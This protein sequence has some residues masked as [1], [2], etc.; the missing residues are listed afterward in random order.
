MSDRRS[1]IS[2]VDLVLLDVMMPE[3]DGF[4]T[5]R[6]LHKPLDRRELLLRVR[7]FCSTRRSTIPP[8]RS[9]FP[10]TAVVIARAP[11]APGQDSARTIP[12]RTA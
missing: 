10:R 2:P 8:R 3:Q 12:K 5:C 9:R 4:A 6:L 11:L 1:T 7:S